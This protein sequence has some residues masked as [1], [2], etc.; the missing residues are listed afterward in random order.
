MKVYLAGPMR[1]YKNF[2]QEAFIA[3]AALLRADG[4]EVWSPYE[5]N[6]SNGLDTNGMT[7]DQDEAERIRPLRECLAADL[8]WICLHADAVAVLPGWE[9]SLGATAEVATARALG[10]PV[11]KM[12]ND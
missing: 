9:N 6:I 11:W 2:N 3:G 7:G 10:L 1:G 12:R 4:H 8:N 5:D